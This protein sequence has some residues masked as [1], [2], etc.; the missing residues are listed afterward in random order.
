MLMA[1]YKAQKHIKKTLF[2]QITQKASNFLKCPMSESMWKGHRDF[3][4]SLQG[5]ILCINMWKSQN[6][7]PYGFPNSSVGKES[8]CTSRNSGSI[9]G[10]GR[11]PL[12]QRIF[13]TQELNWG[14]LLCRLIL[15][16]LSYQG[17]KVAQ[18]C[19][20]LWD[21]MDCIVHGILQA[22]ILEWVAFPF[23]RGSS[24][25]RDPTQ[26]SHIVEGFSTN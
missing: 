18:S 23:F 4:V 3:Y 7:C 13:L 24:Q 14:L 5:H 16:Q 15:Y 10:S 20:T 2:L 9:P 19:Q 21:P 22:R 12:L 8:T 26:V 6:V 25:P 11:S 17:R 1:Q